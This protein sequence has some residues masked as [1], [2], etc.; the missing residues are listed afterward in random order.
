MKEA[1]LSLLAIH[2]W[3]TVYKVVKF[4]YSSMRVAI[5]K[6]TKIN[7]ISAELANEK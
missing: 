7:N 4:S 6:N 2:R 3:L 5:L 1:G